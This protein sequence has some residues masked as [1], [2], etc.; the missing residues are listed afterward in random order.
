MGPDLTDIGSRVTPEWV[1]KWLESPAAFRGA[2]VMPGVADEQ[3][4]RDLAAYL[5]SLRAPSA[6]ATRRS[7]GNEVAPGASLFGSIGCAAC[8]NQPGLSLD[9]MGSKTT[10]TALADYLKNPA[11]TDPGGR[12]PALMLTSEEA[13]QLA[14]YLVESRNTAFEQ[15]WTGGDAA[16]GRALMESE[17]CLACHRVNGAQSRQSVAPLERVS[18]GQGCLAPKPAA[19]VPQYHFTPE[20]RVALDAFLTFY[21]SRP[22]VSPA[23]VYDLRARVRQF[24]CVVCHEL[25]GAAPAAAL[26]EAT[27]P[28][29]GA[30]AKLRTGWIDRVLTGR[31]RV[32]KWQEIRMPDY[33]PRHAHPLT[34]AFAK[35]SGVS[36]GDGESA[37]SS[38]GEQQTQGAGFMGTDARKKGM[39][40]I[41]CHD[42]G[43]HKS[44]GEEAPQLIS[45]TDRLRNDWFHRWML[46]PAR[47]LSGTSMPNYFSSMARPA[48]DEI[49]H[50]LWA[51]M[52]LGERMPLPAGF[53]K[54]ESGADPEAHPVADRRPVVMRWDMPEATPAAIAVG[55]PGKLSYCFDAGESRLRYAWRGGFI[56]VSETLTKK[57]EAN[58]L[59]PTAKLVGAVFYRSDGFPF[60]V[61]SV[62]RIPRPRFRGYRLAAGGAPEFRYEVDGIEVTE[63]I[64]PAADGSGI[65]RQFT[66]ATVDRPMWFI[67]GAKKIEIARGTQVR[68][69]VAETGREN[70]R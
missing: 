29:T 58:H 24:R 7:R 55:L 63:L 37:P 40:C 9:G 1:Y 30:G 36:P 2:A 49:I 8:H 38:T 17:G 23:P 32:R 26:A 53:E 54:L 14:A 34:A 25:D 11:R 56:D 21:R 64:T 44:L 52:S 46:N 20:Q 39:G 51:A 18:P 67:D 62:D 59:T 60:R 27:P 66:I 33:D 50:A 45:V 22:D 31:A 15:R 70:A 61:G 10:A 13:W 19:K 3:H 41:G 68:F 42:W 28:L 43:T 12:M 47:I 48:A 16:R 35:Y 65:T 4:R 57:T 5:V 69:S 6:A